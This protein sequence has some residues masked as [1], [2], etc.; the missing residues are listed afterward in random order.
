MCA[1]QSPSVGSSCFDSVRCLKSALCPIGIPKACLFGV[2]LCAN[3]RLL[4]WGF[5][6]LPFS[7]GLL[8][9]NAFEF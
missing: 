6:L 2:L 4:S 7:M 9:Y 3:S 8:A 1:L 5:Q